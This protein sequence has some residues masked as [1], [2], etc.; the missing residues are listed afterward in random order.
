MHR[1]TPAKMHGAIRQLGMSRGLSEDHA[2]D[3]S[4]VLVETSLYRIDTHG[5]RLLPVYLRELEDGRANSQPKFHIRRNL[6]AVGV[7][8]ADHALGPV[9]AFAAM[10]EVSLLARQFGLGALAEP[11]RRNMN[12]I[13]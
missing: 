8:D 6:P 2:K 4:N 7:F 3:L 9:A 1:L 13:R 5:I 11:I 10:R 12:R